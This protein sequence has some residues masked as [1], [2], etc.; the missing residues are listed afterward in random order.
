MEM[1]SSHLQAA[2]TEP[3]IV[4]SSVAHVAGIYSTH[5][6]PIMSKTDNWILD[7]SASRH[8]CHKHGLFH[9]LRRVYG[10]SVILPTSF[11]VIVE[12]IGDIRLSD[13]LM[14]RDVL[15]VPRFTYNLIFVSCLLQDKSICINFSD[16][17]C[18][19]HDRHQLMTIGRASCLNG[20]YMLTSPDK[21]SPS[22]VATICSAITFT[23]WHHRLG[24]ISSKRL[25]T[26][27]DSLHISTK[28][29]NCSPCRICPLA[30][31][32]RL[33]FPFNNHVAS[34]PFD[35]IHCDVWGPFKNPTYAG[36][37]YFL[38]LR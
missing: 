34:S 22:Y 26:M 4:A 19:I 10:V 5:S 1:L 33:S 30:K 13:K 6:S 7:S 15:F 32:R 12:F 9:N 16:N 31:Q 37:K 28:S 25:L 38:T 17:S 24:H 27:K 8:I 2:N 23:T 20:L 35:V 3:I 18:T 29:P 11:R 36:H 21:L 14:L